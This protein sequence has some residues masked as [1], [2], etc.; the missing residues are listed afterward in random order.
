MSSRRR[1]ALGWA[2]RLNSRTTA[3]RT[4]LIAFWTIRLLLGVGLVLYAFS[5]VGPTPVEPVGLADDGAPDAVASDAVHNL[6][7]TTYRV[8]V[9]AQRVDSEG[10]PSLIFRE[11]RTV[12][13]S[14]HRYVT[15]IEQG[16]A[17][18]NES[19]A[20]ERR[21]GTETTGY[22]HPSGVDG[23]WTRVPRQRYHPSRNTFDGTAEIN[24][25]AA[26]VL[27]N[28]SGTYEVRLEDRAVVREAVNVPGH[29]QRREGNWTATLTLTVDRERERLTRGVYT[30]RG[31]AGDPRVRATYRFEY[32]WGV[33]VDRPLGTYPPGEELFPRLDLGI[34][35]V[36]SVL[37]EVSP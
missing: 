28:T 23:N 36:E 27:T 4:A 8:T 1:W 13:N 22:V 6:R 25:S 2:R 37:R 34:H 31:P 24:G 3:R 29:T 5:F 20:G 14:G 16:A 12:D 9:E 7:T 10:E 32:G 17:L 26:T 21:Y 35:A 19:V 15:R 30:Y 18:T 11:R 33:D